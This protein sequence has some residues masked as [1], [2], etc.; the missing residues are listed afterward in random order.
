MEPSSNLESCIEGKGCALLDVAQVGGGGLSPG[1]CWPLPGAPVSSLGRGK[2]VGGEK[3]SDF[4]GSMLCVTCMLPV[5]MTVGLEIG[6]RNGD[7]DSVFQDVQVFVVPVTQ[8]WRKKASV[9]GGP[10]EEH[11][12]P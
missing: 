1:L 9:L 5:L 3:A 4:A 10:T 8:L 2:G 12:C 6:P 7:A 11:E